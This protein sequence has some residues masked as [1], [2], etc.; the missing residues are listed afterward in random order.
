MNYKL[1]N[2]TNGKKKWILGC[3]G[4]IVAFI[5]LGILL[6][7]CAIFMGNGNNTSNNT[8]HHNNNVSEQSDNSIKEYKIGD[9]AKNDDIDIT[10][11]SVESAKQV[12]PS[13]LP[14]T[15]KDTFVVVDVTI[16]NNGNEALTIDSTMFKLKNGE[17]TA[18]ADAGASTSAN[19]SD[20]GTITN[21]FFLEQVNPDSTTQG[22]VVFDVSQDFANSDK[23]KME[24]KS[25]LFSTNTVIF[26]LNNG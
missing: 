1:E 13:A 4:C 18:N 3:T 26:N 25:K 24:I 16:K 12:G 14:T 19:Q 22:K 23:K 20:D 15:A 21:S 7:A 11:N 5:L 2:K 10:V 8:K 6:G 17:K 9:T